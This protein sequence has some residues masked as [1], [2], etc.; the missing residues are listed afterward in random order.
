MSFTFQFDN[1]IAAHKVWFR[2]LEFFLDGIELDRVELDLIGDPQACSLG[3]WLA[4]IGRKYAGLPDFARLEEA[5]R[6]FHIAGARIIECVRDNRSEAAQS[7]LKNQMSDLSSE[8]VHLLEALKKE[9]HSASR[10]GD[11][12]RL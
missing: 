6:Q 8:I 5:H 7:L 12:P 11:P 2:H 3:Q 4:G 1:A 9:V 10:P